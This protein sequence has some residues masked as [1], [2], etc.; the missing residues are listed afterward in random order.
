MKLLFTIPNITEQQEKQLATQFN[1][2]SFTFL[3]EKEDIANHIKNAEVWVTYGSDVTKELLEEAGELKWI[4]VLSAGV[5]ALPLDEIKKR[6]IVVTNVRGIH[7]IPMSEYALSMLLHVYRHE[8]Q[9]VKDQEKSHWNRKYTVKEITGKT[10]LVLGTGAIGQEVARLG[11]AFRMKT[12]GISRSGDQVE[13]F[14]ENYAV[15]HLDS[16]LPKA[17]FIVSV[18]PSTKETKYLLRDSHFDQM[19]EDAVF[20]NM[21]RGD[22]VTTETLLKA[23]RENKV[24][25]LVLDVF[26]EEPLAEDSPLWKEENITI[27]PHISGVSSRY[28]ERALGILME[29]IECHKKHDEEL[30]NTINLE[31]GY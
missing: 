28:L 2:D 6:G 22:L 24:S 15:A 3:K 21:G 1:K 19:K 18:L 11:R 9:V 23:A 4:Q 12:I 10:L 20:L 14:D 29:N 7:K 27:T 17:D 25:H 16:M 5:N 30:M 13:H 26:E 31:R 8:T